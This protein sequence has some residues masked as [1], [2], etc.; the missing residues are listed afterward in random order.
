MVPTMP[1]TS[2]VIE[3]I[4]LAG[5][6]PWWYSRGSRVSLGSVSVDGGGVCRLATSLMGSLL[7]GSGRAILA[8]WCG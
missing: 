1:P 7:S 8:E 4:Q 5:E 6:R 2:A 3:P